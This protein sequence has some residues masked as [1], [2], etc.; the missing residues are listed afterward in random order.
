M[1]Y[2]NITIVLSTGTKDILVE[3]PNATEAHNKGLSIAHKLSNYGEGPFLSH[4][5][6][7][8][9]PKQRNT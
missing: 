9:V 8:H 7:T 1:R 3:A 6:V 2:Y 4:I 5:I